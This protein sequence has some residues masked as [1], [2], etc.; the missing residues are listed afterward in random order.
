MGGGSN[1]GSQLFKV[2]N[3]L[4]VTPLV[5]SGTF[6]GEGD[7]PVILPGQK[8]SFSFSAGKGQALSFATMY[9]WSNDLFFAPDNPGIAL[10][11]EDGMPLEGDVSDQVKLWDNGTKVNQEPGMDVPEA[12]DEDELI[13]E[14][15]GMDAQGHT[16]LSADELMK[17][18]LTYEGNSVFTCTIENISGGTANETPFSPGVWAISN[19]IGGELLDENP[20]FEEGQKTA[21][22]LQPLAEMGD[23]SLLAGYLSEHTGVVTG[24]S[25]VLVV[26]YQGKNPLF[27]EGEKDRGEG[28]ADIAQTGD[29]MALKTFLE[30]K[31]GVR[32]V[33]VLGDSP[34]TPGNS[35][36]QEID[37]QYGDRITFA[38]MFGSSNDWFYSFDDKGVKAWETGDLTASVKLW[39]DG[40]AVNQY[41]GAGNSQVGFGGA[42][43]TEESE[44]I[45]EVGD[46]YPVPAV[47]DVIHVSL[48]Q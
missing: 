25:P 32:N 6:M 13:M 41:P 26:V 7:P 27:S 45:R 38:T 36:E 18:T 42:P 17:T 22:G 4:E 19:F 23:N 37:F 39:D 31:K 12:P 29:A 16:Y 11:D 47:K 28:L 43:Q 15:D 5:E 33:Y 8:I 48:G 40:T 2:E 1:T 14:I 46:T 34:V 9:G 35:V 20:L 30:E 10:F 3:V 24:L 44:N 21:N